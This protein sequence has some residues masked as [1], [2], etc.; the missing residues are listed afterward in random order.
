M[1]LVCLFLTKFDMLLIPTNPNQNFLARPPWVYHPV[2]AIFS[3]NSHFC[4]FVLSVK[5]EWTMSSVQ[6]IMFERQNKQ[7]GRMTIPI[8]S[9]SLLNIE[10]AVNIQTDICVCI[11]CLSLGWGHPCQPAVRPDPHHPLHILLLPAAGV[12]PAQRHRVRL[13]THHHHGHG[14]VQTQK[15]KA[16]I[17]Y[18]MNSTLAAMHKKICMKFNYAN[19]KL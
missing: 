8:R 3:Y 12:Q 9:L 10:A 14:M 4:L 16:D 11:I 13:R 15:R 6:T 18:S 7:G 2:S 17:I 1:K 19:V 5:N